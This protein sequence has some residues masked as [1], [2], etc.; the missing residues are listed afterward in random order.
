MAIPAFL[1]FIGSMLGCSIVLAIVVKNLSEGFAVSGKKPFVYGTFSAVAASVAAYLASYI[2]ANP[3][4]VFW[5]F[6]G[7]FLLFGILHILFVH[8]R[9]FY[10]HKH[11]GNKVL[12]AEILFGFSVVLFTVVVFAALQ[13]FMKGDRDFLFY[14]I[15]TSTLLFFVPLLFF[16]S[17]QAAYAIPDAVFRT[18][19]YPVGQP[20]ELPEDNPRE[21]LLVTGFEIAK[22]ASD[23]KKTYFRARAYETMKLGDLFY[24]FINDY[25]DLH[26]DTTIE[27]TDREH[28]PYEWCFYKKG[29]WYQLQTILNPEFTI[30]ESGIRENSV[31]ICER[32]ATATRLSKTYNKHYER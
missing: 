22:K 8:N 28:E 15:I 7:L 16:H 25:N 17:F 29:K 5:A 11:N 24:H 10:V 9:Y 23:R 13:Y 12:I 30:R 20:I 6:G 1:G 21:K 14:P 27:Y 31:I 2:S 3:F 26:R 18:W 19:Q 4:S 32:V